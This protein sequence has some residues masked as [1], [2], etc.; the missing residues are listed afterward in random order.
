MRKVTIAIVPTYYYYLFIVFRNPCP[1]HNSA[2]SITYAAVYHQVAGTETSY[3]IRHTDV[4]CP[5]IS[6]PGT[7]QND[8]VQEIQFTKPVGMSDS[9]VE[10]SVLIHASIA[11]GFFPQPRSRHS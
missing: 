11:R 4:T 8:R 9:L 1:N 3:F 6:L 7:L 2:F 5:L 10:H